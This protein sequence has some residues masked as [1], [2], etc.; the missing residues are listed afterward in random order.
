MDHDE[1]EGEGEDIPDME[2]EG[3]ADG[4]PQNTGNMEF[5][6]TPGGVDTAVTVNNSL[7]PPNIPGGTPAPADEGESLFADAPTQIN[8]L[9]A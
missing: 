5:G 2:E 3:E 7:T 1:E 9:G 6:K 4:L 8:K